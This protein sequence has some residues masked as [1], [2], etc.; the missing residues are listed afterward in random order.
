MLRSSPWYTARKKTRTNPNRKSSRNRRIM[1]LSPLRIRE[2]EQAPTKWRRHRRE[3]KS[4]KRAK[5]QRRRITR[6]KTK[7][8]KRQRRLITSKKRRR[9]R[10]PTLL[11]KLSKLGRTRPKLRDKPRTVSR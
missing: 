7:K 5:P 6:R 10:L 1:P 4:R 2:G 11:I 9:L 8:T 3:G